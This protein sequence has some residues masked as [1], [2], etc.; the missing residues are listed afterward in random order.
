[1]KPSVLLLS[2][3]S[4]TGGVLAYIKEIAPAI[5]EWYD[6]HVSI[7]VNKSTKHFVEAIS[8]HGIPVFEVKN[9]LTQRGR[10]GVCYDIVLATAFSPFGYKNFF[11]R[12]ARVAIL[13]HDQVDIFYPEPFQSIYRLGYR[14]LQVPNLNKS[15]AIITVS[16]WA[17]NF[18]RD[19]YKIKQTPYVVPN[20]VDPDR[21]KPANCLE[22]AQAKEKL[23]IESEKAPVVLIPGRLS[24]EKNPFAALYT[25]KLRRD[26]IFL[27]V[28]D[29]ELKGP[30]RFLQR[31]WKLNNVLFLGK[32]KDM[33]VVYQAADVVVQPTLGENQSLTT[34][35]AMASGLPVITTPIPAQKE[36]IEHAKT[37]FFA[38]PE[39][40]V[41]SKMIDKALEN[42]KSIGENARKYV[43]ERH[44][45]QRTAKTL[46]EVIEDIIGNERP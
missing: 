13:L 4:L 9:L 14:M 29:G 38:K 8:S 35:E 18:L 1:M 24:P 31:I 25:A 39:P 43:L 30:L 32:R 21:F 17:A 20:G 19:Y 27:F 5:K 36:L 46:K 2:D 37:G 26:L 45:L 11:R 34:L 42:Q 7:S 16:H 12:F 40:E 28:G 23:G 33:E 3:T 6:V 15:K 41:I 10:E 22:K 44:T